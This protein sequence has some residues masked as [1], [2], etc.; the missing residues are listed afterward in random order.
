MSDGMRV[1]IVGDVK[2]NKLL[3]STASNLQDNSVQACMMACYVFERRA[4][5]YATGNAGGPQVD[6][7]FLRSSI[8]TEEIPNGAIVGPHTDYAADVEFGTEK[9]APYPYMRPAFED[10]EDE[11]KQVMI[12]YL[13][14]KVFIVSSE[15]AS[16]NWKGKKK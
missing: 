8:T 15:G 1:D 16:F 5:W 3:E 14:K 7:G 13:G 2:I 10:E 12:D 6:T 11:A 9:S 4:K